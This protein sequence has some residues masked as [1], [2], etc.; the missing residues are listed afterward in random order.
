MTFVLCS[1]GSELFP[2]VLPYLY[3]LAHIC[4]HGS[5]YS[6]LA[7]ATERFLSVCRPDRCLLQGE[8]GV[9]IE[10]TFSKYFQLWGEPIYNLLY[11]KCGIN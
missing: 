11:S 2:V 9:K 4:Q 7:V 8:K 6:T 10:N 1:Y 3:P 5:I